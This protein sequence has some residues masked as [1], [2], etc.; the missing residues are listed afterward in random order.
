VTFAWS[1]LSR[2][3]QLQLGSQHEDAGEIRVT[4]EPVRKLRVRARHQ[5]EEGR[6]VDDPFVE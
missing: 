5:R 2:I 3:S 4:L 6:L 1:S